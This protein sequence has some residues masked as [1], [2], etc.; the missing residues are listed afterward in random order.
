MDQVPVVYTDENDDGDKGNISGRSWI[1]TYFTDNESNEDDNFIDWCKRYCKD[2]AINIEI[3]PSTNR[4][5]L[6][7][8][9]YF[10]GVKS[11][12]WLA[13]HWPHIWFR[14]AKNV[15]AARQ[16][17]C[18]KR[19]AIGHTESGMEPLEIENI[20][21]R[22]WY[23]WVYKLI[24]NCCKY[25]NQ[26]HIFID[27]NGGMGKTT[28]CRHLFDTSKECLYIASGREGDIMRIAYKENKKNDK[29]FA[30]IDIPRCG[31]EISWSAIE[32]L[33]NG[34]GTCSKYKS[35]TYRRNR[36]L[37]V[38]FTNWDIDNSVIS[39]YRVNKRY[40]N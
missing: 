37:I 34:I 2:Y 28:L 30:L 35:C 18:K 11:R 33:N 25:R 31:R 10:T 6:Q 4:R 17:C 13:D 19:T 15:W 9:W 14:K 39:S 26:I 36:L 24:D 16:Y 27:T 7:F 38:I 12:M 8:Y 21:D 20:E 5:H 3:C 1:G 22:S 40:L 23:K 29:K 32:M